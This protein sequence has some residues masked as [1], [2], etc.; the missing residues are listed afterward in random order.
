MEWKTVRIF[1]VKYRVD[2]E[3]YTYNVR[4]CCKYTVSLYFFI[5]MPP[6]R[7]HL[8]V[9]RAQLHKTVE[10]SFQRTYRRERPSTK[11]SL[12]AFTEFDGK[13]SVLQ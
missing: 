9:C 4:I 12:Y 3:I 6:A 11:L 2:F 13:G 1:E 7:A 10:R 8:T 5:Y